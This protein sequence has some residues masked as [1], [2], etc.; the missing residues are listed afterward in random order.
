[1]ASERRGR[2][3]TLWSMLVALVVSSCAS[4]ITHKFEHRPVDSY[5][6]Q[7]PMRGRIGLLLTS[8]FQNFVYEGVLYGHM[9]RYPMGTALVQNAELL[10]RSLFPDLI[11]IHG[12]KVPNDTALVA[13]L[14]PKFA[15]NIPPKHWGWEETVTTVSLEWTLRNHDGQVMWATT[16]DGEVRAAIGSRFSAASN[17]GK[18][19]GEAL[20]MAFRKSYEKIGTTEEVRSATASSR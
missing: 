6:G 7:Q 15:A 14:V 4:T 16:V 2:T 9:R 19:L 12:D 17:T 8:E 3:V 20:T 1:M 18:Y 11:V 5:V 10:G 13:V